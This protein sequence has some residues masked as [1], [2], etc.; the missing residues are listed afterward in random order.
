VKDRDVIL[1]DSLERPNTKIL[2]LLMVSETAKT[3][4]AYRVGLCAPYLAYMR[5]DE[6]FK[7]GEG[8]TSVYFA[9]L[10]SEYFDWLVTVEPHLHRYHHLDEIYSIPN[11]AL[12]AT[13][14]IARWII[15]NIEKPFLIGPDSESEQWVSQIAKQINS[16]YLILEKNRHGDYEVEISLPKTK[17]SLEYTPVLID[18][19]ISTAQT[20]IEVIK[21]FKLIHAKPLTC[22]G[23]HAVFSK[24]AYALLLQ[25]GAGLVITC[26][27]ILHESNHIDLSSVLAEGIQRQLINLVAH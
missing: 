1:L 9:K 13:Q 11:I 18:D 2:P 6:Q 10:L 22:I 14:T 20:M 15:D 24:D 27:T 8:I 3:L 12:N 16:P 7:T 5:Q 4:G 19:I 25:A 23:I 26:N 21:Q 17:L